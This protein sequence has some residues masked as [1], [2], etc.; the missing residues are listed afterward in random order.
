M[1]QQDKDSKHRITECLQQ[2][3]IRLLESSKSPDLN[4]MENLWHHLK[5]AIHTKHPTN[6]AALKLYIVK[7]IRPRFFHSAVT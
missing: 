5:R 3:K 2:K 6:I 1:M 7:R 4:P